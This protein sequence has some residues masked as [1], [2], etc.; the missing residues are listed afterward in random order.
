MASST[1]S[2]P[3]DSVVAELKANGLT[4]ALSFAVGNYNLLGALGLDVVADILQSLKKG[5]TEAAENTL[6]KNLTADEL[7]EAMLA[8]A[9]AKNQETMTKEAFLKAAAT[10]AENLLPTVLK[11]AATAASGG[12]GSVLL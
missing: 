2:S 7:T 11:Y 3:L 12:I 10:V 9:D 8:D 5:D 1:A 6:D 4:D